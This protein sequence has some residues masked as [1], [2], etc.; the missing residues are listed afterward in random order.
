MNTSKR[1]LTFLKTLQTSDN[2]ELLEC[3]EE[4]FRSVM[5]EGTTLGNIYAH[6]VGMHPTPVGGMMGSEVPA[7]ADMITEDSE[8]CEKRNKKEVAKAHKMD[9]KDDD[10]EI[11]YGHEVK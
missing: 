4:G 9:P 1:F 3:I 2:V 5:V 7:P 11:N 8:A 10:F 6:Q